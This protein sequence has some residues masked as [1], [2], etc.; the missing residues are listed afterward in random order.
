M[1]IFGGMSASEDSK[2]AAEISKD[3]AKQ[4]QGINDSKQRAMELSG[5]RQSMEIVR[6][7]QRAM[8]LAENNAV[9]QGAQFGSGIQGGLAQISGQSTTNLFGVSSALATGREI[10]GFN[11]KI[12]GDKMQMADVQ[13]DIAQD[14][15]WSSLGGSIMKA[16]PVIG[17][18]GKGFDFKGMNFG[19][20]LFGGGSPSGYGIG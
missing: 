1:Q 16:G 7:A 19:G 12:S 10:A 4:E 8:A 17:A 11:Q 14:Q 3:V 20:S 9:N 5:R 18:F 2:K 6:N 15:A 13:S